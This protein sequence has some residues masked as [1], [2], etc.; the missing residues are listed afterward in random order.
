MASELII[1]VVRDD[2]E[3][4]RADGGR[5]SVAVG[6]LEGFGGVA[7]EVSSREYAQYDGAEVMA[8]RTPA[9]DRTCAMRANFDPALARDEAMA[10]FIPHRS[11]T[12]RCTFLGRTRHCVGRLYALD[13][14]LGAAPAPAV[15]TWTVLCAQPFW[16]SEDE[17][18]I[19]IVEAVPHRGFPFLSDEW[20]GGGFVVGE[21]SHETRLVNGGHVPAYPRFTLTASGTVKRPSVRVLDARGEAVMSVAMG[22][23]MQAGDVLVLDFEARPTR[24]EL[25]GSNVSHMAVPGSTLAASIG[26]GA[27]TLAWDAE[28]G[29]A[30]LRVVPSIRERYTGI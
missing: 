12:V 15:A 4:L 28:S 25:N 18:G 8:E 17:H 29:D 19:D 24:I 20:H 1:E 9:Q 13:V 23:D 21:V 11:Y 5:W 22:L 16:L 6:G 14:E 26:V 7:Y 27:Y 3:V 2:G 10:F 30:A